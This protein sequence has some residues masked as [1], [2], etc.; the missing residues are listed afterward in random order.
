LAAAG[1]LK[2][3]EIVSK[4]GVCTH[5][6]GTWRSRFADHRMDGLYDEPRPGHR[7][8]LATTKSRARSAKRWPLRVRRGNKHQRHAHCRLVRSRPRARD[9][10]R[11]LPPRSPRLAD[12]TEAVV[13][14]HGDRDQSS[15]WICLLI[16][17]SASVELDLVWGLLRIVTRSQGSRA[18]QN[19]RRPSS[20]FA[21]RHEIP[22][23]FQW[24]RFADADLAC[25]IFLRRSPRQ[26]R[27]G[28][29]NMSNKSGAEDHC[30]IRNDFCRNCSSRQ[31]NLFSMNKAVERH[32]AAKYDISAAHSGTAASRPRR[33]T[34]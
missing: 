5:T 10:R 2:R 23:R 25:A 26:W 21:G 13:R 1:G 12:W 22:L 6:V 7:A 8:R 16:E 4:L 20:A 14:S 18:W 30:N 17:C 9:W 33:I 29:C 15:H 28:A 11:P 24:H 34:A 19:R 32:G 3:K 27:Q 31:P